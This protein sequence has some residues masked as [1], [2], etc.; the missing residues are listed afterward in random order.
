M[1][2]F[3]AF[4]EQHCHQEETDKASSRVGK[5][6]EPATPER[7]EC[8]VRAENS[9]VLRRISLTVD[10]QLERPRGLGLRW[11]KH[12]KYKRV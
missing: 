12:L 1:A 6:D 8:F 11:L 7:K 9:P 5:P 2:G 4:V 10:G 3:P